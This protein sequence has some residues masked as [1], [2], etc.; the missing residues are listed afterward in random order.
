MCKCAYAFSII[1]LDKEYAVKFE[2]HWK[3]FSFP[4][5][6]EIGI[7]YQLLKY[8]KWKKKHC[9]GLVLTRK[10]WKVKNEWTSGSKYLIFSQICLECIISRWPIVWRHRQFDCIHFISLHLLATGSG[11]YILIVNRLKNLFFTHP[12]YKC[13]CIH[14]CIHTYTSRILGRRKEGLQ[15]IVFRVFIRILC[16]LKSL[17]NLT[18]T[19]QMYVV[20]IRLRIC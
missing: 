4:I 5:S 13:T 6:E 10:Y 19:F 11:I 14:A 9:L 7:F 18:M 3:S 1:F 2:I 15:W 8:E 16:R 20:H 17:Y 12:S